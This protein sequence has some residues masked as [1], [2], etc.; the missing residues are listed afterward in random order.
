[1]LK[2]NNMQKYDEIV[3]CCKCGKEFIKEMT[4][5]NG[6]VDAKR[7]SSYLCPYCGECY[8]IT[9]R[10]NEDVSSRKID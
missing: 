4:Y 7:K 2:G 6:S 1:M 3:N 5:Y 9:L 10:C 8:H